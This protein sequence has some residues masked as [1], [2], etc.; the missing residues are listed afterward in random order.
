[1]EKKEDFLETISLSGENAFFRIWIR[2]VSYAM[3]IVVTLAGVYATSS[4]NEQIQLRNDFN[5]LRIEVAE[6][7]GIKPQ[8]DSLQDFIAETR[9]DQISRTDRISSLEAKISFLSD[10][11]IELKDSIIRIEQKGTK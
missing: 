3:P 2:I 4:H 11:I 7:K 6:L 10:R 8:L 5:T 9:R 1:M